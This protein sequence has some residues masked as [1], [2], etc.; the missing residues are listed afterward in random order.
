MQIIRID[1]T[2]IDLL[3]QFIKNPDEISPFF[4]YFQ[5]RDPLAA[6]KNHVYTIVGLEN[7]NVVAYGHIDYETKYWFGI[8][9]LNSYHGKGYGKQIMKSIIEFADSNS[10]DMTLSV[11]SANVV[12]IDL[13]KR[14]GF[15]EIKRV[16]TVIYM[17][18]KSI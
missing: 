17:K 15:N 4:R 10:I 3:Y 13:Y 18:R 16:D 6:F 5:T 8:C 14:N 7:E 2:N 9:V 12:A 11:D 1:S